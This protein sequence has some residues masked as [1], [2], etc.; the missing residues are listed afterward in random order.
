MDES[1][2]PL[3]EHLAELRSRLVKA[4]VA[5]ILASIGAWTWKEEIFAALLAPAV[6]ALGG[7]KGHLQAIAPPDPQLASVEPAKATA[8]PGPSGTSS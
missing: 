6:H 4:I 7:G 2:L 5:W 3:T 8:E 1:R